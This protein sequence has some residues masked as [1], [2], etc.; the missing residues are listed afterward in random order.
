MTSEE[1]KNAIE[2]AYNETIRQH[3]LN[4]G[5]TLVDEDGTLITPEMQVQKLEVRSGGFSEKAIKTLEANLYPNRPEFLEALRS[6]FRDIGI[7]Q[8]TPPAEEKK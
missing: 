3:V 5:V 7:T 1:E 2:K 8:E 6:H 4:G